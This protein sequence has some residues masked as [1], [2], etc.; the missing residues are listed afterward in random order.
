M[1]GNTF[2]TFTLSMLVLVVLL[3]IFAVLVV[4]NLLIGLYV[5][6]S[7]LR[8]EAMLTGFLLVLGAGVVVVDMVA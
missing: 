4:V 7:P 2:P 5:Q 1:L 8:N 3:P 6:P